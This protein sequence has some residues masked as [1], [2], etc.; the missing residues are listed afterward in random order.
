[1][2][3]HIHITRYSFLRLWCCCQAFPQWSNA[4][5]EHIRCAHKRQNNYNNNERKETKNTKYK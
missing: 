2:N 3:M 5:L 1:M 4:K